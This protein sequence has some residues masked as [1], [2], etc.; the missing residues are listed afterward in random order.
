M[1]LL[2]NKNKSEIIKLCQSFNIKSLY[3]FGSA[4]REDFRPESDFD[5]LIEV[6]EN[7]SNPMQA[8]N[9]YLLLQSALENLLGHKV[10]LIDYSQLNNPY[11]KHFINQEKIVVYAEA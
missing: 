1:N 6:K 7:P 5:F 10:D 8:F 11:L 2:L 3:V 4:V 9:N